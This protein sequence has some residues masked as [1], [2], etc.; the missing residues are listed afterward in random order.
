MPQSHFIDIDSDSIHEAKLKVGSRVKL[1]GARKREVIG[2]LSEATGSV[3]FLCSLL[4]VVRN[5]QYP[6]LIQATG[7]YCA[8]NAVANLVPLSEEIRKD[9]EEGGK[10][11]PLE[12]LSEMLS[13]R[14]GLCM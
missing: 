10:Q 1:T 11:L 5:V 2:A 9:L 3:V 12:K 14:Q 4:G 8:L 13:N 7:E 6:S